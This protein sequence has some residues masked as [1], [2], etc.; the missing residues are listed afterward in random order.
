MKNELSFE[1]A[2]RLF[3]YDPKA[4]KLRWRISP[5]R[6]VPAG[7]LTGI[8]KANR[9]G[10]KYLYVRYANRDVMASHVAWL[11]VKG[12]LPTRRIKFR[13]GDPLNIRWINLTLAGLRKTKRPDNW[14]FSPRKGQT[15][16]EELRRFFDYD[17]ETGRITWKI[18]PA[19]HIQAG[20]DAGGR[21]HMVKGKAYIYLTFGGRQTPAAQAAWALSCGEWPRGNVLFA[22]GDTSNLRLANLKLRNETLYAE[23]GSRKV[24]TR[25]MRDYG[26][27]RYYKLESGERERMVVAQKGLCAICWQPEKRRNR[28]GAIVALHVDHDHETG[29]VRALLCYTCNSGL[30]S[31]RDDPALLRAAADYILDPSA[32]SRRTVAAA[33]T[34]TAHVALGG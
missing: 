2:S 30:G 33:S 20:A 25:A 12:E 34:V 26:A 10:R 22:D 7:S 9:A 18:S 15:S 1:K 32:V 27:R 5:A 13:D 19:K 21:G 24:S 28:N 11:L 17:P 8:A 6:N 23:P 16:I 3:E 31:F 29:A 14:E 4:G